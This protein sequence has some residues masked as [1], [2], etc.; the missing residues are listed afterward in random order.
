MARST[1]TRTVIPM[2]NYVSADICPQTRLDG[3]SRAR[4]TTKRGYEVLLA[5]QKL[6]TKDR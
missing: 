6:T 4:H 3:Q 2:E 1:T 5:Y